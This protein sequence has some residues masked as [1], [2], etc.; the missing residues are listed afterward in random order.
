[1]SKEQTFHLAKVANNPKDF[2]HLTIITMY[3]V[4]ALVSFSKEY[5]F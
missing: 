2:K 5:R 1:M 3:L 4:Y